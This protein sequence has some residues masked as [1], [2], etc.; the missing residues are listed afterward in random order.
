MT[1]FIS[2][3]DGKPSDQ[4]NG[5]RETASPEIMFFTCAYHQIHWGLMMSSLSKIILEE[6]RN[7]Q[8]EIMFIEN[9]DVYSN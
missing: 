8:F 2:K 9:L 6:S 1:I 3:T 5:L 4:W 7:N